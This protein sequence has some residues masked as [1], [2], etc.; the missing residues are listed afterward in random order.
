M[1]TNRL[2]DIRL[3]K[4]RFFDL[5]SDLRNSRFHNFKNHLNAY[6]EF[7]ETNPVMKEITGPL[8]ENSTID[9][10]NWWE[11]I[12]KTGGSMV[13]SKQYVLP[14]DVEI[15]GSLLY[16]FILGINEGTFDIITFTVNVY[17]HK[18]FDDNIYEFNNDIARKLTRTLNYKLEELEEDEKMK[19]KRP[20]KVETT[21]PKVV[22]VVHGRNIKAKTAMFNFLRALGLKPM[23]WSQAVAAT[24]KSSPYIGEVLDK[25][26]FLAQ[27]IVVLMTPDDEARLRQPYV[28]VDDPDYERNLTG[29]PRQNVLFEAGMAIGRNQNRTILV[30]LGNLRHF[31]DILG[32]HTIR[33]ENNPEKRNDLATRLR[34]AGCEVDRTGSDWIKEGDFDG[35]IEE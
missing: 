22:F 8:K 34:T 7:C 17:G 27:A 9:L 15:Q 10:Q 18:R 20:P 13:G 3:A 4:R 19:T 31:S 6:V 14:T 11:D 5:Q 2:R 32:R 23:E 25:V 16:R 30:E 26:F 24:G 1:S 29:Q 33:I 12:F 35:A 21:D 28:V